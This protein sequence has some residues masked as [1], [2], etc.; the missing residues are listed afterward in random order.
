MT[1]GESRDR[2]VILAAG[3]TPAWQQILVFDSLR[4]GEVNRAV[5]TH[6]CASG[7]IL[8]VGLALHSLGAPSLN[9]AIIGGPQGEI[10][11]REF[12]ALG[13]PHRWVRSQSPTRACTTLLDRASAV[14]TELVQNAEPVRAEELE[15]FARL[16]EDEVRRACMVILIG[17]LPVGTPKT[18]Y[19]DLIE[20]TSVRV[21]LDASGPE[22]L[23]ALPLKPFCVKPNR[24]ELGK[25]LGRDLE[26][27]SDLKEAMTHVNSLGANWAVVSQGDRQLWASSG[28]HIFAFHP[29]KIEAVNPI[30]SGDCLAAGIACGV[31]SGM[32]MLE[33]IRL[34][35]AA[36]VEN[37]AALLPARLNPER[38]K[39]RIADISK[40]R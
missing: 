35:I 31:A 23:A 14:S 13:I 3:L 16:Y 6:W 40:G 34:G 8:N 7:K 26:S 4:F 21:I 33:A 9:L 39:S 20:K 12:T 30:G 2:S 38:V 19:R 32:D 1:S 11:D 37:A 25:T 5:E 22:L 17:S 36:G 15:E 24:E 18:F 29:P 28:G 27:D 10:I